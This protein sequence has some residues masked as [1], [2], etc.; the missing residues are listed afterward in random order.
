V[1]HLNDANSGR[2]ADWRYLW[3]V[4]ALALAARVAVGLSTDSVAHP[5]VL[6]QYLEQAHRLVFGYGI[7]PWEYVFGIRS[8]L[9]P[10]CIAL[11]LKCLAVAGLS[12][13]D[14]YVPIVKIAFCCVSLSLP[15]SM[16]RIAQALFDEIAA[17]FSLLAGAFW[18]ELINVAHQPLVDALSA[19]AFF[20]A[21]VCL[22]AGDTRTKRILF[23]LL[24]GLA[25]D[26]RFQLA[27]MLGI[28]YLIAAYRWRREVFAAVMATAAMVIA[29]GAL[30]AYTWG[31]W[32]SSVV[33]NLQ[34][35]LVSN[36]AN[37][38]GTNP[39]WFYGGSLTLLSLG[40]A[41]VGAA[42]L[43]VHWRKAWPLI[44][45]GL[46]D[47]G[48]FSLIGHKEPR[49]VFA[50]IPVYLIGLGV[51]AAAVW[52]SDVPRTARSLGNGRPAAIA[53]S[54]AVG[55]ISLGGLFYVLPFERM[56]IH[57]PLLWRDDSA[58]AY[59]YLSR[60]TDVAGVIDESGTDWDNTGGFYLLHH[61]VPLYGPVLTRHVMS[62]VRRQPA[63]Y[64][65]HWILP[66]GHGAPEAFSALARVGDLEIWRRRRDV[67]VTPAAPGYTRRAPFPVHLSA[68][69]TVSPRW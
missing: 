19:Y 42:A 7:I 12:R 66:A 43:L 6:F 59:L 34:L 48:A 10:G 33:V 28:A 55:L 9:V 69:P 35:N 45:F 26:L 16:Y 52:R 11:L 49:F 32:F 15:W 57:H 41:E 1:N 5:D 23:G 68:R 63:L 31:I 50:S 62:V 17:R 56:A 58:E 64:A 18:Y 54:L 37:R 39:F 14:E 21:L 22:F 4:L 51:L 3:P 61:P 30:D 27:P 8:W 46:A 2:D 67:P 24:I 29:L 47:V 36:V 13:P 60:Q 40:L 38:F 44:L 20:A 53:L 65:S 25:L